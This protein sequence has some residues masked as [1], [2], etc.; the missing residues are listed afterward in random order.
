MNYVDANF[1]TALHYKIQG[2]TSIE[3]KFVL[4][5]SIPFLFSSLA[6]LECRRAFIIQ[7]GHLHSESWLRLAGK[8]NAGEWFRFQM[9]WDQAADK[10]VQLIDKYGAKLRAGILD[11]LHVALALLSGCTCFLS[12]DTNSNARVLAASAR[13]K[14]YP[15]LSAAEKGR[16][17]R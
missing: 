8:L 15:D 13:L 12:F 17:M 9:P 3:E 7:D 11:T 4:R 16:V 10:S 5:T 6:E 1:A 14:V 2:Q